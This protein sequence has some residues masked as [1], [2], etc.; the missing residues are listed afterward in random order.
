VWFKTKLSVSLVY[1][2]NKHDV[3]FLHDVTLVQTT[4]WKPKTEAACN[5]KTAASTYKKHAH[6]TTVWNTKTW[7]WTESQMSTWQHKFKNIYFVLYPVISLNSTVFLC[8]SIFITL[9]LVLCI[10]QLNAH[11]THDWILYL[12]RPLKSHG[13]CQCSNNQEL[14][15][16][17]PW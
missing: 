12:P 11:A 15:S 4:Y 10:D 3:C 7:K 14:V 5:A 16:G 9:K 13:V 17:R 1:A 8:L 2:Q 6:R